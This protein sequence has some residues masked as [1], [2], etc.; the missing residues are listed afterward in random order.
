MVTL[1]WILTILSIFSYV[2]YPITLLLIRSLKKKYTLRY[3][4]GTNQKTTIII[5]AFNEES[6][7][8]AKIEDT[9][10]LF[11]T[12]ELP[13][14]IVA[15]DC[16]TDNTDEIV[17]GYQDKGIKLVRAKE[18]LGK[19]NAQKE[20][21]EVATGEILVFTDV[22][23]IIEKESINAALRYFSDPAIGAVSSVDK[24]VT[25]SGEL[26][27]EGIYLKYEMLLRKLESDVNT[28]VGLSGSFFIARKEL[29]RD[30]NTQIPSDFNVALTCARNG[31]KAISAPDVIGLY[32]DIK[33]STNEYPRKRRTILRGMSALYSNAELLLPVAHPLFSFQLW[34]HKIFRWGVPWFQAGALISNIYLADTHLFYQIMLTMHVLLISIALVGAVCTPQLSSSWI[35]IPTF[36]MQVNIASAHALIDFL[37]GKRAVTWTPSK[38]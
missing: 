11:E 24:M 8:G 27:G 13:E 35:R 16:S 36:F 9:L 4:N 31:L 33:N 26:A 32:P 34:S 17:K 20:A 37:Q 6:R 23:T 7:I 22:A 2:I 25:E 1:F 21:I 29:C 15:S 12:T 10:A 18:R 38:R 5:T 14:I 3:H 19:E 30:W 28:L